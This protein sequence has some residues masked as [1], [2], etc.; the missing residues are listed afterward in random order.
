M[1]DTEGLMKRWKHEDECTN[2]NEPREGQVQRDR[3]SSLEWPEIE[4]E[5]VLRCESG[6]QD[7]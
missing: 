5:G 7:K 2:D 3:S 1:I 4:E 6:V